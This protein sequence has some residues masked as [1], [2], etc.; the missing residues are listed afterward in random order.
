[1]L[2]GS[3]RAPLITHE[4]LQDT[5]RARL[6]IEGGTVTESAGLR[7]KAVPLD[8]LERLADEITQARQ[9]KEGVPVSL[10]K[11]RVFHFTDLQGRLPRA[12]A[13][14]TAVLA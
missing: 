14:T 10:E 8:V 5:R 2:N 6:L 12:T 9:S 11:N 1:M 4:H 7:L 3:T 13:I